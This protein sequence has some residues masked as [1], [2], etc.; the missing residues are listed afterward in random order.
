MQLSVK[1]GFFGD[2]TLEFHYPSRYEEELSSVLNEA[3]LEHE[4]VLAHSDVPDVFIEAIKV[5]G[6]GGGAATLVTA[7]SVALTSLVKTIAH[8]ND[9]K[10]VVLDGQEVS[11]SSPKEVD[12]ILREHAQRLRERDTSEGPD[13]QDD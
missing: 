2:S 4:P 9:G 5:L 11:G 6:P 7:L 8:R 13:G 3:G 12:R 1:L 10:R